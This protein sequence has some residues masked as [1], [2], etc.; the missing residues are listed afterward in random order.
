MNTNMSSIMS[1]HFIQN[2]PDYDEIWNTG[3]NQLVT[4]ITRIAFV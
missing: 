3:V 2:R 1:V 4:M